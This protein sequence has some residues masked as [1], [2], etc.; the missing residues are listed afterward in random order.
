MTDLLSEYTTE[1]EL[2]EALSVTVE[3]LRTWASRRKGPGGRA[4]FGRRI[5]YR[6]TAVQAWMESQERGMV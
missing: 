4:K 3:T 2:S 1:Q 6:K 5:V